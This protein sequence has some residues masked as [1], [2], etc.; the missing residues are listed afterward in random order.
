MNA[1][2]VKH[3]GMMQSFKVAAVA[4]NGENGEAAR[5]P[6][7]D[8]APIKL[9]V[10]ALHHTPCAVPNRPGNVLKPMDDGVAR[11]VLVQLEDGSGTRSATITCRAIEYTVA[12]FDQLQVVARIEVELVKDL[13]TASV[14]AHLVDDAEI[15]RATGARGAV[16]VTV[17]GGE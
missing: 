5:N 12:A 10:A 3:W 15:V 8:P 6:I 1:A 4:I 2:V 7:T 9:P 14:R 17:A 11:A 13:I 16:E